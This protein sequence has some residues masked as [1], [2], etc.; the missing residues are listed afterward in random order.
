MN[1]PSLIA[2]FDLFAERPRPVRID[3][4]AAELPFSIGRP[5]RRRRQ[6]AARAPMRAT[7]WSVAPPS[8]HAP[9]VDSRD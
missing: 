8:S 9:S 4:G 7:A 5:G 2:R 3:V 1:S 6:I